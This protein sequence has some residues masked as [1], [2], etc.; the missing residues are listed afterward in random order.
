MFVDTSKYGT[1]LNYFYTARQALQAGEK[2]YDDVSKYEDEESN[3]FGRSYNYAIGALTLGGFRKMYAGLTGKEHKLFSKDTFVHDS[4]IGSK[5]KPGG[6]IFGGRVT[7]F[8]QKAAFGYLAFGYDDGWDIALNAAYIGAWK[9]L[10]H[11]DKAYGLSAYDRFMAGA[12]ETYR[13]SHGSEVMDAI[14]RKPR[15]KQIRRYMASKRQRVKWGAARYG[16][17]GAERMREARS[18]YYEARK[19]ALKNIADMKVGLVG[20][21]VVPKDVNIG[22]A[23]EKLKQ[24]ELLQIVKERERFGNM[25]RWRNDDGEKLKRRFERIEK[26]LY[27]DAGETQHIYTKANLMKLK[28]IDNV[29]DL[30]KSRGVNMLKG[31]GG[32]LMALAPVIGLGLYKA[33]E[34]TFEAINYGV[35]RLEE[36]AALDFGEGFVPLSGAAQSERE[37]A[38]QAIADA[39]LNARTGFG[40]EAALLH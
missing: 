30:I 26:A 22:R 23:Y 34:K 38:L 1:G 20:D 14:I 29:K 13:G 24:K 2:Y 4:I 27:P 8:I 15:M 16:K 33:G 35:N 7:P 37:R 17:K 12:A 3:I 32:G 6:G 11:R 10:E 18:R 28:D 31:V 19:Q 25:K 21:K 40:N 39:S 36:V 5:N 9:Y